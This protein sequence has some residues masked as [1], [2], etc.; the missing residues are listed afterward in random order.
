VCFEICHRNSLGT[1]TVMFVNF[2]TANLLSKNYVIQGVGQNVCV[3]ELLDTVFYLHF[4]ICQYNSG[5]G[6]ISHNMVASLWDRTSVMC[7]L[8][9][10]ASISD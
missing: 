7:I 1:V 2:E 8:L 6:I 9:P 10:E 3:Q 5:F 4:K